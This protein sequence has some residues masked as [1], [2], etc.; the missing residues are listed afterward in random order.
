MGLVCWLL[1][2]VMRGAEGT[3][4]G[5]THDVGGDFL[6]LGGCGTGGG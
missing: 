2:E 3:G 1:V 5:E 6:F 4:G